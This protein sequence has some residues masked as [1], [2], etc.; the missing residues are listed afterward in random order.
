MQ[1]PCSLSLSWLMDALAVAFIGSSSGKNIRIDSQIPWIS[2]RVLTAA[3][4]V[5]NNYL[6]SLNEDVN[7]ASGAI[8]IRFKRRHPSREA[9][10]GLSVRCAPNLLRACHHQLVNLT[11]GPNPSIT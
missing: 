10:T 8:A 4:V 3:L 5:P 6:N 9:L 1:L 7:P 2:S 11:L